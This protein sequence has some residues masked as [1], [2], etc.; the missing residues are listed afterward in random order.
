MTEAA[1]PPPSHLWDVWEQ[2]RT[3]KGALAGTLVLGVLVLA[4]LLG[5]TIWGVDPQY[6]NI[7]ARD[8][9]PRQ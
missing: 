3:H 9:G 1:R 4:V 2:F 8:Q 5:P 6:I 7:R